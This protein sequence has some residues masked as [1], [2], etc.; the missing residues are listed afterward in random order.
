MRSRIKLSLSRK[1]SMFK[2]IHKLPL[3]SQ[4]V[5]TRTGWSTCQSSTQVHWNACVRHDV[6]SHWTVSAHEYFRTQSS[7][8]R[9]KDFCFISDLVHIW[10]KILSRW[11]IF[12]TV[13]KNLFY[14]GNHGFTILL[15]LTTTPENNTAEGTT[16]HKN[17]VPWFLQKQQACVYWNIW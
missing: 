3:F 8:I 4:L 17:D 2:N 10:N 6:T 7:S 1:L 16:R 12:I 13:W 14:A 15:I 9:L 11:K 5:K